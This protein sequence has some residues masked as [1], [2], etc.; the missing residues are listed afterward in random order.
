MSSTESYYRDLILFIDREL[1]ISS[2]EEGKSGEVV[3]TEKIITDMSQGENPIIRGYDDEVF[4][5]ENPGDKTM[6]NAFHLDEESESSLSVYVTYYKRENNIFRVS[7]SEVE[8]VLRKLD[9]FMKKVENSPLSLLSVIEEDHPLYG[10][11]YNVSSNINVYDSVNYIFLTNGI[12]GEIKLPQFKFHGHKVDVSLIDIER[13]RRYSEGQKILDIVA[14]LDILGHPIKCSHLHSNGGYDVYSCILSG[15]TIYR[16]F[17]EFHFSL[18]NSNIRTYLQLKGSVNQGIMGT[19]KASPAMFLAY[20]NGISATA[21]QIQL[22]SEGSIISIKDFQIVNGGQTSASIYKAK[23]DY[24]VSLDDV[25]VQAKITVVKDKQLYDSIV[26]NISRYANTQNRIKASDFSANDSYNVSLAKL[27][28]K[29]Y[30]PLIGVKLPTKWFYENIEGEYNIELNQ[31]GSR[32]HFEKEYPKIQKFGKT[33][34]AAYELAYQGFPSQACKGA[35]DAY[36]FFVNSMSDF[37]APTENDFKVIIAK[38]ILYDTALSIVGEEQ[39]QG[40]KAMTA[41]IISYLS[42]VVCQGKL[43]LKEIW[44][45]Q[46]VS[47][48]LKMDIRSLARQICP[49]LRKEAVEMQKSVEMYCRRPQTWEEFKEKKY[50]VSNLNFYL[51]SV[52]LKPTLSNRKIK[53]TMAKILQ[54]MDSLT[55]LN[56]AKNGNVLG[57]KNN[58]IID[59]CMSMAKLNLKDLSEK[60]VGYALK[61]VYKFYSAGYPFNDTIKKLIEAGRG[62]FDSLKNLR[63]NTLSS[64]HY[65]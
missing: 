22:D 56:M 11:I 8:S 53:L 47:E 61:I 52:E 62:D 26:R 59:M 29:I 35:Q 16:L 41:Y 46:S 64:D 2:G 57:E 15:N 34:L 39:G 19:L 28:R 13:Y 27:S 49:E 20:N 42:A 10:F 6:I 33:E 45:N 30:S 4:R 36:K 43:D 17:D 50:L 37:S 23:A 14:G 21:S 40:K 7:S 54:Y 55:W 58:S 31:S 48:E 51:G 5:Y 12:V 38:K 24:G 60:Q 65:F 18:L 44:D 9:N 63:L 25:Y 3:F 32:S 1:E